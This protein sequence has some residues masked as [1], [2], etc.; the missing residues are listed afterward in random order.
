MTVEIRDDEKYYVYVTF[1]TTNTY[2]GKLIRFSTR[3]QYSHVTISFDASLSKMYSFARYHINSPISGGFVV[4]EPER[5][6]NNNGDVQIK[7]CKIPLEKDEYHRMVKEFTY[8]QENKEQMLYNTLNAV[9]SLL[10]IKLSMKDSYTCLEFVTYL[11][12]MNNIHAIRELERRLDQYL[13]YTGSF[14]EIVKKNRETKKEDEYF[15]K[16]HRIGVVT[17]TVFHFQ[18]IMLRLIRA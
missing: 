1:F 13:V 2:M 17:D 6:L 16:R 9:L 12:H 15:M 18:K 14:R 7:L 11:L 3:N 4:E 8:F 5:Y 10:K